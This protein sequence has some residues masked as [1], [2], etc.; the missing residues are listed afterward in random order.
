MRHAFAKTLLLVA[1]ISVFSAMAFADGV[2]VGYLSYDVTSSNT[3]QFDITNQTGPNS[4]IFPDTT[5]PVSNTIFLSSLSLTVNFSNGTTQVFG[6]SYFTLNSDGISFVGNPLSTLNPVSNA[7]LTGAFSTT[8]FNLNNGT[9]V[10]VGSTFSATLLPSSGTTLQDQDF[11]VIYGNTS[12]AT[13]PEPESL[14]L[15]GTGLAALMAFRRK[16]LAVG[17][18]RLLTARVGSATIVLGLCCVM[19]VFVASPAAMAGVVGGVKLNTWT[20]PDSGAAGVSFTNITGSG[21]PSGTIAPASVNIAIATSCFGTGAVTTTALKVTKII[22]TSERIE[23]LIPAAITTTG[24][25]FASITGKTTTGTSFASSNCSE[26]T[27]TA[28]TKGLS[29]CLPSSSLGVLTGTTTVQ[30]YVPKGYWE[31]GT[32]GIEFVPIEGGGANAAISTANVVNACSSNSVTGQTVCTANNTDVYLITGSTLTKTLTS[33]SN[34]SAGFSG[35]SCENC[36]VA[37]NALSNTAYIE[38]GYNFADAIQALNLATNAFSTPTQT[39]NAVS[40]NISVDPTRNLILSPGEGGVYDLFQIGT[41]GALTEYGNSV[42]GKLDSAAEDCSTGIALASVEFTEDVFIA[43]LTQAKFT[44]GSPGTWTAPNQFLAIPDFEFFAAGTNGISVAPGTAHLGIVTG[45]FGGSEFGV[46][47]LPA[48][49]GSGTPNLADWAGANIP[50]TPDGSGF[51]M[52]FDP[53]TITA[54]VSPNSQKAF[55]LIADWATGEPT[56]LAVIDLK[57]LLAAPRLAGVDAGGNSCPSCTHS[58][59]PSYDLVAHGVISF[60]KAN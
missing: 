2:P 24:N 33:G 44:S 46:L 53:H 34:S 60:V 30:A 37:I 20:N 42:G 54:Y 7:T 49:S 14:T 1:A 12:V 22:G 58:V 9:S 26:V 56:Y 35:G 55:G 39:V 31:S 50:A 3:F 38:M 6:S 59:D 41:T 5:W 17:L 48:T 32:T 19:L 21:F 52:G 13:T 25:Y 23:F 51:S 8:T 27:I 28:S 29:S 16:Y 11:V 10:T 57:A 18:K 47:S 43:D 4:S 36:G 15:M 45:E 40:E